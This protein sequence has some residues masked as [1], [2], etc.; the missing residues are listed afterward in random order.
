MEKH[1]NSLFD[2][3]VNE[4]SF[5]EKG[6]A[7]P[8]L[9]H[10]NRPQSMDEFIGHERIFSDYPFLKRADFRIISKRL[11]GGDALSGCEDFVSMVTHL[12]HAGPYLFAR[13]TPFL[14]RK[15]PATPTLNPI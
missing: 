11:W 13:S 1:Q 5:G 4:D 12:K 9:A 6:K 10:K 3:T 2:T 8:P 7:L 14:P 15:F